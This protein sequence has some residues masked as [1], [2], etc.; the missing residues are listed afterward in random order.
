MVTS[1]PTLREPE[2]SSTPAPFSSKQ[3]I[4][5]RSLEDRL[6][7]KKALFVFCDN[8]HEEASR[9]LLEMSS[10]NFIPGVFETM[11]WTSLLRK[12][13]SLELDM[14]L[15]CS[16]PPFAVIHDFADFRSGLIEFRRKN[17][18]AAAL[19]MTLYSNV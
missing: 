6:S 5:E 4:T 7:G 1:V 17:P 8:Q 9:L 16:Q 14:L 18:L 15:I 12:L 2:R 3:P 13:P 19:M 10:L 11:N